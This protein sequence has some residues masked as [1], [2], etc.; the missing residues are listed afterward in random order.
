M[1]SLPPYLD[2][3]FSRTRFLAPTCVVFSVL[4]HNRGCLGSLE[5]KAARA[6]G[7]WDTKVEDRML[8]LKVLKV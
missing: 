3:R 1:L 5:R 7:P 4:P 8:A 6:E 2:G